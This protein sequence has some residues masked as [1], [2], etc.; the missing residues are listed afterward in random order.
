MGSIG[1]LIGYAIFGLIAG[2]IARLINPG[3]DPMSWLWTMILGI[4]GAVVGGYI[5]RFTGM[6]NRGLYGWMTA[7]GG[8]LLLLMLYNFTTKRAA[9]AG[10]SASDPS[11]T[12][13]STTSDYKKAVFDDLSRGP[14]G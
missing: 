3:R 5:G 13:T 4:A 10:P 9:I 8:S 7:I 1:D 12:G 11:L 14:N 2:A 6:D